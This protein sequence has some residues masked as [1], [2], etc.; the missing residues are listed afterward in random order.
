MRFWASAAEVDDPHLLPAAITPPATAEPARPR[1]NRSSYAA[2]RVARVRAVG[3]ISPKPDERGD[4]VGKGKME[5]DRAREGRA[6]NVFIVDDDGDFRAV[7][8][9]LLR[10]EG[11]KVYEAE[12]GELALRM[13]RVVL[14]DLVFLDLVMPVKDGWTL[15][16]E[17]RARPELRHVPVAVLSAVPDAG[18]FPGARVLKKPITLPVLLELLDEVDRARMR[19]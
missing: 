16:A 14:P 5:Q 3:T 15:L 12:N 18:P 17:M 4:R 2:N 11:C 1:K 10:G 7:L 9:E 6:S 13:L 19:S 8:A